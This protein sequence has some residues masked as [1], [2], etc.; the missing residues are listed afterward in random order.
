M[1]QAL[2]LQLLKSFQQ[3]KSFLLFVLTIKK[4]FVKTKAVMK[5]NSL[6]S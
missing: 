1:V 2:T 5:S 6:M 4:A 3:I